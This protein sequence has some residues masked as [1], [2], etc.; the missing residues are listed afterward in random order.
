[1]NEKAKN[2]LRGHLIDLVAG[3][4]FGSVIFLVVFFGISPGYLSLASWTVLYLAS[5]LAYINI[6]YFKTRIKES[7][8]SPRVIVPA[9][10]AYTIGVIVSGAAAVFY[11]ANQLW[12]GTL[13]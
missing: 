3:F 1:M 9:F 2:H 13:L 8:R 12:S 5:F 11:A 4:L 6:P 10:L 7:S